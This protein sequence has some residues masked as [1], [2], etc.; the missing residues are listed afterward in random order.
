MNASPVPRYSGVLITRPWEQGIEISRRIAEA[1]GQTWAFPTIEIRALALDPRWVRGLLEN[2]D[3]L[4]FIS[5]NAVQQGW[6]L[7]QQVPL[8]SCR[9]AA[10]GRA[11]ARRLASV[12]QLP[13]LFPSAGADSESLLALPELA[14][15]GQQKVV[16]VRGRGG[17]E[18]L[19]QA[20]ESRG[21]QVNYLE[22]YERCLPQPE[23]AT[24]DEA[25]A[26]NAVISVQSAEA[27]RNLWRLAGDSRQAVMR[28]LA[29]LVP[30]PRVADAALS[31]GI[32]EVHVTGAGDDALLDY[33]KNLKHRHHD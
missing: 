22:C 21:A 14:Q 7:I 12:S 17:R 28:Q 24:L 20:L 29:F 5:A 11:T 13:V 27:L 10:V 18:W 9:L 15:M 16:I 30:H 3:W 19:K 4:I 25:L 6:P 2:A 32:V 33:W 23:L 8:H 26:G 1:G 31:L